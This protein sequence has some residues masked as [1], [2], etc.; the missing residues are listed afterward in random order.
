MFNGRR[1]GVNSFSNEVYMPCLL[2]LLF[3]LSLTCIYIPYYI[4]HQ[5][6]VYRKIIYKLKTADQFFYKK[7][8]FDALT[9]YTDIVNEYPNFEYGITKTATCLFALIEPDR[10]QGY[11]DLGM[12]YLS[13]LKKIDTSTIK[14]IE[15]YVPNDY[16]NEFK[17]Y[18]IWR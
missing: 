9:N 3:T 13:R 12:Y 6:P 2:L 16:K 17:N 7:Q 14:E 8:Y 5:L 10:N 4:K 15:K 18:F 1:E 11:F